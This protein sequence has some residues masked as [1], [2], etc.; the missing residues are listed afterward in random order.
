MLVGLEGGGKSGSIDAVLSRLTLAAC[1][2]QLPILQAPGDVVD[3]LYDF[4]RAIDP[5]T[6]KTLQRNGVKDNA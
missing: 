4:Q 3:E 2:P 6:E 1:D 5:P